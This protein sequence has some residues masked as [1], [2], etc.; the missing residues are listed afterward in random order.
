VEP[1]RVSADTPVRERTGV[2][3]TLP[4]LRV[5]G[6]G[7]GLEAGLT[8]RENDFRFSRRAADP[9]V[10]SSYAGLELFAAAFGGWRRVHQLHGAR[11]LREGPGMAP[12]PD[13]VTLGE[14][15]GLVAERDRVRGAG[16]GRLLTVTAA[17]CV[18][19]YLAWSGGYGLLHAGW[20]GT[21]AG[22]LEAGLAAAAAPVGELRVHLG[23]AIGG[24][25]YEVGPEV[26]AALY[27]ARGGPEAGLAEGALT[28]GRDDRWMLDLR[29]ALA[30]RALVAGLDP[31][32]V[33]VSGRCTAC[34][35]AFHSFRAGGEP[36][37][38]HVMLAFL[39]ARLRTPELAIRRGIG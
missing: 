21:A 18:P 12:G 13:G 15:D 8:T 1:V 35:G 27:R 23:P 20:R 7:E 37:V 26:V 6:L 4:A 24:C 22:V 34:D 11:V 33:S 14:A 30:A 10:A 16:P 2:A 9:A 29:A 19:V 28:P 32:R 5:E 31:A 3:G 38:R 39:G 17:D 36:H 25:C